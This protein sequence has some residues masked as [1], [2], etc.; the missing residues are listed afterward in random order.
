MFAS[1]RAHSSVL[2]ATLLAVGQLTVG[3]KPNSP[4]VVSDNDPTALAIPE[5]RER[6]SKAKDQLTLLQRS[7]SLH[8][9]ADVLEAEVASLHSAKFSDYQTVCSMTDAS[10][11][12]NFPKVLA[13]CVVE[14]STQG[15]NS[16]TEYNLQRFAHHAQRC[17]GLMSSDSPNRIQ[18]AR[19][20]LE[21]I[22]EL[23]LL[24]EGP[25]QEPDPPVSATPF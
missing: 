5:L 24:K 1:P 10:L 8:R 9:L 25:S 14:P 6:F 23:P 13:L 15:T 17:A 12:R 20:F 7:P 11:R 3:C 19:A 16:Q 18:H 2:L 22:K 21:L 4:K